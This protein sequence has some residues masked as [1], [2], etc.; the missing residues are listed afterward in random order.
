MLCL[1]SNDRQRRGADARDTEINKK[2]SELIIEAVREEKGRGCGIL[3][4]A[5]CP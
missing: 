3:S 4:A 2:I 5:E 1:P